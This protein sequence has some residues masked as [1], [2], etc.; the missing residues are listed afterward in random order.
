[1]GF[2]ERMRLFAKDTIS[3]PLWAAFGVTKKTR[4]ARTVEYQPLALP[5]SGATRFRCLP[6]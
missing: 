4:L 2:E 1:M 6:C 5:P 3:Q